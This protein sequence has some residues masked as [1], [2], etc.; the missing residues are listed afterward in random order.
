MGN[1][2]FTDRDTQIYICSFFGSRN[3]SLESIKF[4]TFL[5]SGVCVCVCKYDRF[6]YN[7]R[8]FLYS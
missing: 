5:Y 6:T 3:A 4:G 7:F 2:F 1:S 8:D